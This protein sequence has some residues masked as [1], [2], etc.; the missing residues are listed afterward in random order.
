MTE[1]EID[2]LSAIE[3]RAEANGVMDLVWLNGQE[4]RALKPAVVDRI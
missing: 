3:A 4:A 1:A 2:K